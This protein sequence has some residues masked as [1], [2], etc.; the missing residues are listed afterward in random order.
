MG[1]LLEVHLHQ[2]LEFVR[3]RRRQNDP[4]D[5]AVAGVGGPVDETGRLRTRD[6][7]AGTVMPKDEVFGHLAD[8]R[9]VGTG[10]TP[11]REQKLVMRW[12][13]A[14]GFDLKLAPAQKPA[15]AGPQL[16][17]MLEV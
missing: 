11:D 6:Q 15:Q 10:V 17:E 9:P 12:R 8:G 3:A 16:E 7:F 2:V 14:D 13:D 5:A 1:E 4:D